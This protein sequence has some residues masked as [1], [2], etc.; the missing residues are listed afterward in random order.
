MGVRPLRRGVPHP[1]ATASNRGGG[2]PARLGVASDLSVIQVGCGHLSHDHVPKWS[3]LSSS[4][5][6]SQPP[7]SRVSTCGGAG[8][9][10]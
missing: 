6:V 8:A 3:T 4:L 7:G 1:G 5:T 10:S 2:Q 9:R